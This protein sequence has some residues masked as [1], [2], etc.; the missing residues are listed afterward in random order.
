MFSHLCNPK[1][2]HNLWSV[3]QLISTQIT[4]NTVSLSEYLRMA[5]GEFSWNI[6]SPSVIL[7]HTPECM[8]L[9]MESTSY[10]PGFKC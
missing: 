7:I 10:K 3:S 2:K 9:F 8:V 4:L 5:K 6:S 1:I